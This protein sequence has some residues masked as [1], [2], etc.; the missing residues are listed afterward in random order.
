[1]PNLAL[2]SESGEYGFKLLQDL[3]GA[4]SYQIQRDVKPWWAHSTNVIAYPSKDLAPV[5][6][7]KLTIES[8]IGDPSAAGFHSDEHGQPYSVIQYTGN[9]DDDCQTCSHEAIEMLLDPSGNWLAAP[10]PVTDIV[11]AA[12]TGDVVASGGPFSGLAR[13]LIEACDPPEAFGYRINGILVSDFCL[14]AYFRAPIPNHF[15]AGTWLNKC[16]PF[17]LAEGGYISWL[18]LSDNHWYQLDYGQPVSDLGPNDKKAREGKS[19]RDWIDGLRR[20]RK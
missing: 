13:A 4:L 17:Q 12:L 18:N 20:A 1:M 16:A 3:A 10:V 19:I 7:W 5:E 11:P 6:S 2:I 8:D 14:P 15:Q 9:W